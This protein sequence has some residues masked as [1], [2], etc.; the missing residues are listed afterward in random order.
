MIFFF[1]E[2]ILILYFSLVRKLVFSLSVGIGSPRCDYPQF[3]AFANVSVSQASAREREREREKR[4]ERSDQPQWRGREIQAR[5]NREGSKQ[6]TREK[7]VAEFWRRTKRD[8]R[9]FGSR[10]GLRNQVFFSFS[11]HFLLFFSVS[12]FSLSVFVHPQPSIEYR[13]CHICCFCEYLFDFLLFFS[14]L[15]WIFFEV[16]LGGKRS[17]Y[18]PFCSLR[19][20]LCRPERQRQRGIL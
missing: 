12:F 10:S 5:T 2:L 9:Q 14:K 13:L 15:C 11:K 16:S 6:A 18:A 20:R 19:L 17:S 4:E 3:P 8:L 7:E 1:L